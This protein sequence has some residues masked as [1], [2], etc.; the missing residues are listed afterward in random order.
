VSPPVAESPG[1]VGAGEPGA[2]W[3]DP[4]VLAAVGRFV[5]ETL[6]K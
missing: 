4:A 3:R 2:A 5:R 6:R 1:G